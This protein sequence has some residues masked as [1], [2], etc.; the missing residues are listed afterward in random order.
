MKFFTTVTVV[1]LILIALMHVLRL[2]WGWDVTVNG[3]AIPMWAS[4]AGFFVAVGLAVG[5]WREKDMRSS[6][7]QNSN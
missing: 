1:F 4:V 3:I 2:W 5:L 7:R 6:R